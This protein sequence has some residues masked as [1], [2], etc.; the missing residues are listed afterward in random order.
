VL[1][2]PGDAVADDVMKELSRELPNPMMP[3]SE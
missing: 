3:V 1:R 2:E